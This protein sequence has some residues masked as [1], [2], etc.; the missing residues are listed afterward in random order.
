MREEFNKKFKELEEYEK[1]VIME[2]K[3]TDNYINWL[4]KF[5]LKN[6]I[7]DNSFVYNFNIDINDIENINNLR[8]FFDI[9]NGYAEENNI[10][11]LVNEERYIKYCIKHNDIYYLISHDNVEG[12]LRLERLPKNK[13]SKIN[14]YIDFRDIQ[15]NKMEVDLDILKSQQ[16]YRLASILY[17]YSKETPFESLEETID[18]LEKD[19]E[20]EK[21]KVKKLGTK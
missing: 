3:N 19:F 5:T 8:T 18:N 1:N 10:S 14:S 9:I 7:F 20:K 11:P 6:P 16:R 4:E 21:A 15:N 12:I 2:M 17:G 13:V